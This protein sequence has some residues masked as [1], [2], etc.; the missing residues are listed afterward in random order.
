MKSKKEVATEIN[1]IT[2]SFAFKKQIVDEIE[3]GLV[4][5]RH[6]FIKYSMHRQTVQRW[7]KKYGSFDKKLAAM[8]GKSPKQ[9]IL[10]LRKRVKDLELEKEVLDMAIDIVSE[11][12]GEDVRK[13]YLPES[14]TNG[15]KAKRKS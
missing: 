8:G 1:A 7:F 11:I 4:S 5:I 9:E 13:K 2:Y 10:L 12:Y 3:Q 14:L 6:A 15:R